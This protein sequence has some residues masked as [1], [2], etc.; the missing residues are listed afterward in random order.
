MPRTT[1]PR[2]PR[3][4]DV[5]A[6]LARGRA[7]RAAA[8]AAAGRRAGRFLAGLTRRTMGAAIAITG[9]AV[10]RYRR[11]RRRR[12]VID[13]L[14]G[15]SD[16]ALKDIGLH[17]SQIGSVATEFLDAETPAPAKVAAARPMTQR[18]LAA[19]IAVPCNDNAVP[20]N[21]NAGSIAA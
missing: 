14:N 18:P 5:S 4:G 2:I 7:A 6:L 9:T 8:F 20:C 19:A 12:A 15:L 21:D 16:A 13:G 1:T 11:D 17:R 10:A 3:N